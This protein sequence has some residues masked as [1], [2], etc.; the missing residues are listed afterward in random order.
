M[1]WSLAILGFFVHID[2]EQDP[3][4]ALAA[5]AVA[6]GLLWFIVSQARHREERKAEAERQTPASRPRNW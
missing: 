4:G 5:A 2:A 6:A 3:W 1:P